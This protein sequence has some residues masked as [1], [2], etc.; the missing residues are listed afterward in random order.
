[1]NGVLLLDKPAGPTSHDMVN[2]V[3]RLT[4]TRKVGHAGTL[5]PFA[6]GLLVLLIGNATKISN[7]L[8]NQDKT[9]LATI[10]YGTATDT[11]DRTGKVLE[12]MDAPLPGREQI[13]KVL[14]TFIGQ[15]SQIPP[16]FS[17][18]KVNGQPLYRAARRGKK[19]VRTAKK[20][21]VYGIELEAVE[22]NTFTIRVRCSKGT[23]VRVLA[24]KMARELGGVGHLEAL[25]REQSGRF[26]LDQAHTLEEYKV[27]AQEDTLAEMLIS[28]DQAL[29]SYGRVTLTD[30]A[31]DRLINGMAPSLSDISEFDAFKRGETLRL[32]T[33][34][35][36]L[37]AMAR[38]RLDAEEVQQQLQG[39]R[40]FELLRVFSPTME[41]L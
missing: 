4:N 28:P 22:A 26:S 41:A 7:F 21:T 37:L 34:E 27:L 9:Y 24:D 23:Y 30:S 5:D 15:S 31:G 10:A 11:L 17:A 25:R 18:K 35:G 32:M 38:A 39:E 13:L 16:M 12:E 19:V 1:M 36:R 40:P 3:R 20:I 2:A 29:A 8:L 14:E 6:T 33:P